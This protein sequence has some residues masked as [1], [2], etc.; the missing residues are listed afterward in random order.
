MTGGVGWQLLGWLAFVLNVWGNFEIANK[1]MRGWL[2]R[3]VWAGGS[4]R[5]CTSPL[6]R[7]ANARLVSGRG[8]APTPRPMERREGSDDGVP[9]DFR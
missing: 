1:T 4:G 5:A 3:I 7:L 9:H 2:I 8:V 6:A